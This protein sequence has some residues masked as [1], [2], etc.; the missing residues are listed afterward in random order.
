MG[1][2]GEDDDEPPDTDAHA[3]S[4]SQDDIHSILAH[5]QRRELL[6]YLV[7]TSD[8][9]VTVDECVDHLVDRA[10]ERTGE[11]PDGDQVERILHHVHVPRLVDAGVAEYDARSREIRYWGHEEL[12]S[13]LDRGDADRPGPD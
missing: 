7:E 9:T 1:T 12:E 5:R 13:W 11:R 3:V 8:P 4:L 10:D 6:R 2:N